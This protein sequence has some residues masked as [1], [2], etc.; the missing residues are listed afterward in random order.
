MEIGYLCTKCQSENNVVACDEEENLT[1]AD[2]RTTEILR[3]HYGNDHGY[4][5]VTYVK[6]PDSDVF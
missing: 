3:T 4:A 2:S 5:Y 6:S 1:I